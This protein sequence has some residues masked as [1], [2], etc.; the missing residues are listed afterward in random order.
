MDVTNYLIVESMTNW[1]IDKKNGFTYFGMTNRYIKLAAGIK[2]GDRLFAYVSGRMCFSD[3]RVV[4]KHG[5]HKLGIEG[6]YDRALPI[7]I[8]TAPLLTLQPNQ[9]LPIA[10]L[11]DQLMLT[12][13]RERKNWSK[14]LQSTP[15][16]IEPAD[17]HIIETKMRDTYTG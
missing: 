9:W 11:I 5:Y 6:E 17:A 7:C 12:K 2:P 8:A 4:T 10:G 16:R 14:I 3:I 13:E 1:E 15:R